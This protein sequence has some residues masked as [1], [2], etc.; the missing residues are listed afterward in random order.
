MKRERKKTLDN[1]INLEPGDRVTINRSQIDGIIQWVNFEDGDV[2]VYV[3]AGG[4]IVC[5]ILDLTPHINRVLKPIE[6]MNEEEIRKEILLLRESRK[7]GIKSSR[8]KTPKESKPKVELPDKEDE[9]GIP[10]SLRK[11]LPP[12]KIAA[13]EKSLREKKEED[14][15]KNAIG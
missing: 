15:K 9:L 2:S 1:L 13:L 14:E 12:E 6:D 11:L 5:K 8:K 10:D 3:G 7:I 4:Y